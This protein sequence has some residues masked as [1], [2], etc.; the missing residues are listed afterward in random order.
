[1]RT[2]HFG[3]VAAVVMS[4]TTFAGSAQVAAVSVL[5][6]GGS[7]AA[8]AVAALLLNLRYAPIGI[9]V[10]H[11][12]RGHVLRRLSESQLI[13]DESWALAGGGTPRFDR[14]VLLGVGMAIWFAWVAG[15]AVGA[16]L[17]QAIGDP[18]AFGLDGAFT[19]LFVA[20]LAAQLRSRRAIA[21]AVGGAAI[22]AILTPFTPA[23]VPI[24]AATAAIVVGWR[25]R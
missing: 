13:V 3:T 2:A 8:A 25:R 16:L 23:G 22:A 17:G 18:S 24:V 20:L 21:A 4:M 5:A 19:A 14:L 11:A 7:V 6:A 1:A 15:T 10:A 9:T 12:F